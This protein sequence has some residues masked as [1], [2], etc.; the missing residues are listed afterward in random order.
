MKKR[1][2][3]IAYY[4]V[5]MTREQKWVLAYC[6]FGFLLN[7]LAF[8]PGVTIG[9]DVFAQYIQARDFNINNWHPA[10]MQLVWAFFLLFSKGGLGI[11]LFHLSMVW[12]SIYLLYDYF[13]NSLW[14]FFLL[15][16]P[17]LPLVVN[18]TS[19][20]WKDVALASSLLLATS[21]IIRQFYKN[22]AGF[23]IILLLLFYASTVRH[24][25]FFATAPIIFLLVFLKYEKKSRLIKILASLAI[26]IG[27]KAISIAIVAS[28]LVKDKGKFNT[29]GIINYGA[30]YFS[31]ANN[32]SY[33]ND[34]SLQNIRKYH[35]MYFQ[36]TNVLCDC[37][38]WPENPK[39]DLYTNGLG[40]FNTFD[41]NAVQQPV[42]T[43][44]FKNLLPAIKLLSQQ[45]AYFLRSPS[46]APWWITG[47]NNNNRDEIAAMIPHVD[48][49]LSLEEV[50]KE[51]K[52]F[53][54]PHLLSRVNFNF[55]ARF[56]YDFF[57]KPYFYLL[58]LFNIFIASFFINDKKH[59]RDVVL[60]RVINA[61]GIIY[62]V[63][64]SLLM[65]TNDFRFIYWSVFAFLLS[66]L[67]LF[68][69]GLGK[70]LIKKSTFTLSFK[71]KMLEFF[72][73][74]RFYRINGKALKKS[75]S[76]HSPRKI[77]ALVGLMIINSIVW[78]NFGNITWG[79]PENFLI[80]QIDNVVSL[81]NN[82]IKT[83]FNAN[84]HGE[85]KLN[86]GD[87][88]FNIYRVKAAQKPDVLAFDYQCL[89]FHGNQNQ[90][91]IITIDSKNIYDAKPNKLIIDKT[92]TE[93]FYHDLNGIVMIDLAYIDNYKK[94]PA[95]NQLAI[96]VPRESCRKM[97][98]SNVRVANWQK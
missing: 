96:S 2:S 7:L 71:K 94:I 1:L 88:A 23:V 81:D 58:M 6:L 24:N 37:N 17:F 61:S 27:I 47:F 60:L 41:T 64:Y 14:K 77:I 54:R 56:D 87:A 26:V 10:I 74:F 73:S 22:T 44:W 90:N 35:L 67:W 43:L 62:I 95:I 30:L 86:W 97:T 66:G 48:P 46:L 63:H 38:H 89:P 39:Q 31:M 25:G 3:S 83:T 76:Q 36:G 15:L 28:P 18:F 91:F 33:F 51:V 59:H 78:G 32:Q 13:K 82:L 52:N 49:T 34:L 50:N 65:Q 53:T 79:K 72:L 19:I 93:K 8:Y 55:M 29:R 57:Y 5:A 42:T 4:F 98:I 21:L 70:E 80:K 45:F 69:N 84:K 20:V 12:L 85:Y 11:W 40:S 9:Y 68:R 16:I 92:N 75:I